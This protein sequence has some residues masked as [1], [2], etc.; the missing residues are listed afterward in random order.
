V[1]VRGALVFV[2]VV[3]LS[4]PTAAVE[5]IRYL[6]SLENPEQHIL[7]VEMDIPPGRPS[8]QLQL[9][10]WNALYQIRDFVQYLSSMSADDPAGHRLVITELNA[11]RWKLM[12]TEPGVRIRYQMRVDNPGPYGAEMNR[13][14]AFF[15]LA[16][17]LV[18]A[19]E[20][21]NQAVH[22]EF[23]K[24][25]SH[26]RIAT[27]LREESGG[28]GADN[29]DQL[30]DSP[31]E[32]GKFRERDFGAKCGQYRVI[33]DEA[34]AAPDQNG[35]KA[36]LDRLL[37]PLE[38]IVAAAAEWMDDCP[39][40]H[41]MF[42]FHFSDAAGHGGMEHSYS[43][44]INLSRKYLDTRPD[45]VFSISAHEFFHLWNVKRI[46]P[47]SLEP[48]DYTKENYTRALWF[49]EGVDSTVGEYLRLRAGLVDEKAYLHHLSG[50]ITDLENRPAHRT[51]SVEQ[52]SLEAWLEKY[53]AYSLP[54]RS[55]SYYNKGEL[56]GV[57]LDL[58]LRRVSGDRVSLRELF[59]WMNEH[60]AKQ[61]KFFDDSEGVR[62]AAE[63]VSRAD[64][65]DF[66]AR[67]VHGLD[68]IPWDDFFAPVGLHVVRN[69]V[70]FS[71]P[72]FSAVQKF[73]QPP[74]VVTVDR[75]SPAERAGLKS[76]D[77]AMAING[78]QVGRSFEADLAQ[79]AP[80]STLRLEIQREGLPYQLEFKLGSRKQDIFQL[81]DL[82]Q[83]SAGQ[84][85]RRN[86]WLFGK[87]DQT[88]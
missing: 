9:P 59:R 43:T 1:T 20:E 85:A 67:Y 39:F 81:Q 84:R 11:S 63:G 47:Q 38:E 70:E 3:L 5:P 88:Q 40:E 86:A 46:R 2:A 21:R 65:S 30:V 74:V 78:Q 48:I 4:R 50:E 76:G 7:G 52:S 51:Q 34:S 42:L 71:S 79:L 6:I 18:Y 73:D 8:Y 87:A 45:Q 22:L 41:Y 13:N 27:P 83:L 62:Q 60:Y 68:E 29:Y 54:E 15:N 10:V 82:P 23:R 53:P 12:G 24:L 57:L 58:V 33:V 37:P 56:L 35:G 66:F 17:I 55:I 19:E 64:L 36:I 28:F 31:V 14:H 61:G 80:G 69:Q 77:T 26:W 72:G 16:E 32:I 49:S 75:D 25:P 44:A